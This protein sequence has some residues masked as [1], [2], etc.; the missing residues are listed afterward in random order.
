MALHLCLGGP[1]AEVSDDQVRKSLWAV[2]EQL[3]PR[4]S[5]IALPPDFTRV[6]S[7]AGWITGVAH[8]YYADRLTDV[9]PAL[10][11][12]VPMSAAQWSRMFPGL[13]MSLARAPLAGGRGDH[14]AG[15]RRFCSAQHG[16]RLRSRVAGGVEPAD[17]GGGPR[18]DPVDR[19]GRAA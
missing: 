17:L 5:V 11:T 12:H 1:T 6:H 13:P 14:W 19:P 8:D 7:R 10:G 16:G 9:M 18:A 15:S 2:F 4:R 3:G